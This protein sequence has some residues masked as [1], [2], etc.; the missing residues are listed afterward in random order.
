MQEFKVQVSNF[1]AELG[2]TAGGVVNAVTKSGTNQFHGSFYEFVR[3]DKF[4]ATRL[5][6]RRQPA[7]AAE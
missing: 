1:G 2:H 3:N 5:G 6:R 4:D 7:F